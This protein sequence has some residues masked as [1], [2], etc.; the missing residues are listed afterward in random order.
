MGKCLYLVCRAGHAIL[1]KI[2]DDID[3]FGLSATSQFTRYIE[4]D[5]V[6]KER[7]EQDVY[8]RFVFLIFDLT[9]II[10]K[11][12]NFNNLLAVMRKHLN[13]INQIPW[14][15]KPVVNIN[16][17]L[18]MTIPLLDRPSLDLKVELI[19]LGD[20]NVSCLMSK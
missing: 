6:N 18:N 7:E 14:P 2:L 20:W 1:G 8:E 10:H 4:L 19:L 11:L 9:F 17:I 12:T 3:L 15:T 5:R 16:K 13:Q